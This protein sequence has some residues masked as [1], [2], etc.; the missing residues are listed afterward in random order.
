MKQ[1]ADMEETRIAGFSRNVFFLGLTSLFTDIASEMVY[2][3]I[4]I[5]LTS[6]LGAPIA[7]VGLVEGIAESTA[8][9]AKAYSGRLSDRLGRRKSLAVIG[10]GMAM[11]AKPL[12]ALSVIWPQVLAARFIDRLGKGVRTSPR[13]ALI[14]DS[15]TPG[16]YGRSF[17]FHRGMDTVGA[18][19]GPLLAFVLLPLL[20]NNFRLFFV[21]ALIPAALGV[22]VLAAFVRETPEAALEGGPLP[23]FRGFDRRFKLF[24]L[25]IFVFTLGNSSD[26]FLI[27]RARNLGVAVV[28][29]PIVYFTFN[30]V[31]A[32]LATPVGALSDRIGRKT[33][34]ALGYIFYALVY[35][36]FGLAGSQL[37][38][39]LLFPAYGFYYAFSEGI[40]KA[41]TADIIPPERRGTAFGLLN[42]TLGIGLLPA[43]LIAGWLWQ[44]VS[45]RAPFF[46]GSAVSLLALT[47]FI[48]FVPG[49]GSGRRGLV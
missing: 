29:I 26:A 6:V 36:G 13:D 39:W 44:A 31:H 40:F 45:P 16:E 30:M 35:L 33:V 37:A 49:E 17:G 41:F 21:L 9:L 18:A 2:P 22:M 46:F 38:V 11:A 48:V 14:A 7:V 28:L 34:I 24:L 23:T 20:R 5:F 4:P 25:V 32:L 8:S 19:L 27:L 47:L 10:Y 12:L 15:S 3:L 43:A 42:L 1:E